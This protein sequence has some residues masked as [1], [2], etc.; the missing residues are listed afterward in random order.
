MKTRITCLLFVVIPVLY[1]SCDSFKNKNQDA[2]SIST[3]ADVPAA[4][5]SFHP[6]SGI[7][8]DSASISKFLSENTLFEAFK[9]DFDTFYHANNYNYAWYDKNGLIETSSALIAALQNIEQQGVKADI[10]YKDSLEQLLHTANDAQNTAPDITTELMLTGEYFFYAKKIWEGALNK[11]AT[12]INWYIPRKKLSYPALLESNLKAGTITD[13]IGL[14]VVNNQYK[15]LK[16]ALG[17]YREIEN[18]GNEVEVPSIKGNAVIKVNDSSA[19]VAAVRKRLYQLGD[20]ATADSNRIYDTVLAGI[21]GNI[22]VRYGL[23]PDGTINNLFINAINVPAK[24]RAEQIMVNMERLRWIPADTSEEFILVNIPDY[25]LIYYENAKPVWRCGVVVGTPMTKTV[26]F[27]G[28]MRYVVFSPYWYVPTSIINK[29]VKPGMARSKT[30]LARH[31]M[32][33]N[34]GNIRQKPGPSNSLGLV[35]FLFPNSNNIYLHDTPSKSLFKETNRAFSHGCIRVSQ[36]KEL[37]IRV[38]RQLP[39]WTP[40]KIDVAMHAGKE[41]YVTLKRTIPVYIGYFTAFMGVDG[42]VNFRTDIYKRD[43]VL[44]SMLIQE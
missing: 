37:A 36:P 13:T 35:K 40:G 6:N 9:N 44:L 16:K 11:K 12:S 28:D 5:G 27:S 1:I 38:L 42:T 30:Y 22:K 19:I 14:A 8:I 29:D 4:S 32:E 3:V 2:D 18:A 7:K 39:E 43:D 41:Q 31:N 34:G 21:I 24:K 10:P 33:W 26:I 20:V 25:T 15:G 23:K 17:Q